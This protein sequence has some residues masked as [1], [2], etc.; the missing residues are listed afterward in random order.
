MKYAFT[1]KCANFILELFGK[2]KPCLLQSSKSW[3][4]VECR[5][6]LFT[7]LTREAL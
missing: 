2:A 3:H 7:P 6:F 1:L 4:T 5:A